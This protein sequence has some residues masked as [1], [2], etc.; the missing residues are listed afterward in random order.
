[1][2]WYPIRW[3]HFRKGSSSIHATH[4][5]PTSS[6]H[7]AGSK[8]T[9]QEESLCTYKDEHQR[10]QATRHASRKEQE[11]LAL[12]WV[13]SATSPREQSPPALCLLVPGPHLCI[14]SVTCT[15]YSLP[16][17]FSVLLSGL[18]ARWH[19][20]PFYPVRVIWWEFCHPTV[21]HIITRGIMFGSRLS[22]Q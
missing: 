19:L 8:Q 4:K 14:S 11:K 13:A 7:A 10:Q 2:T 20:S 12:L 9:E 17:E 16:F 6:I 1:M 18:S 22:R 15:R 3:L 21:L 5:F